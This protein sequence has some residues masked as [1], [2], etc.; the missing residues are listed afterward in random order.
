ML[1][2][3]KVLSF[4]LI[5]R[6]DKYLMVCEASNKW[7]GKWYLPGGKVDPGEDPEDAAVR[8]TQ[9]EAGCRIA[10]KG[11]FFF[12]YI[13]GL[14]KDKMHLFY[15]GIALDNN[16][17]TFA[18]KHSLE[19]RWFSYE[20]IKNLPLRNNALEVIESFRKSRTLLPL[21][22]MQILKEATQT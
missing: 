2:K 16:I 20:E 3:L 1:T 14:L 18:D 10:V 13:S 8:E 9:E 6:E 7:R 21:E 17:K 12:R 4:A 5:E 22:N 11:L 19:A 15:H